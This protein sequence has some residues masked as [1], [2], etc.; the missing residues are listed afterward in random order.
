MQ[1]MANFIN[2]KCNNNIVIVILDCD[3]R[4]MLKDFAKT[5]A[6]VLVDSIIE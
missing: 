3:T 5:T 4:F 2:E 1:A 6:E